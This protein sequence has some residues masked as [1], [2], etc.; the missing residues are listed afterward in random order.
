MNATADLLFAVVKANTEASRVAFEAGHR[1]G[2]MDGY[3]AAMADAK[4]I[5][6]EGFKKPE[7]VQL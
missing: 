5:V 6:S 3:R 1:A 7:E 2:Y 4:Q